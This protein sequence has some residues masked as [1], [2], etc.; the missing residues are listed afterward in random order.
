MCVCVCVCVN[1]QHL[2]YL[3]MRVWSSYI[4]HSIGDNYFCALNKI[5]GGED[6]ISRD[7]VNIYVIRNVQGNE[8]QFFYVLLTVH[9]SI[10]LV[11]NQLHA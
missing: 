2:E 9:L 10:I 5:D 6:R 3:C 8:L 7:L 11:I 1:V 4:R